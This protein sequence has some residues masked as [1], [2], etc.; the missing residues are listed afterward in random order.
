MIVAM[1]VMQMTVIVGVVLMHATIL[2][3][4]GQNPAWGSAR[5]TKRNEGNV[6]THETRTQHE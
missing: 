6:A 1:M 3:S 5:A 2:F 4:H